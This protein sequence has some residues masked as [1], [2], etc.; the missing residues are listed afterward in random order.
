MRLSETRASQ[1]NS[2]KVTTWLLSEDQEMGLRDLQLGTERKSV[3]SCRESPCEITQRLQLPRPHSPATAV[4]TPNV[5]AAGRSRTEA[6][7]LSATLKPRRCHHSAYG[8]LV[9]G[10]FFVFCFLSWPGPFTK[11]PRRQCRRSGVTCALPGSAV[12]Q[13]LEFT[14]EAVELSH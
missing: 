6:G 5:P 8:S 3:S 4:S 7:G 1:H 11:R 9:P 13:L 12:G 2:N 14:G 10:K